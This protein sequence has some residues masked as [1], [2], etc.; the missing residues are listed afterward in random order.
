MSEQ[1]EQWKA[2]YQKLEKRPPR[3][4]FQK[5][6]AAIEQRGLTS[7]LAVD[8]GCGDGTE[9]MALLSAGWSVMAIDQSAYAIERVMTG[10][11]PGGSDRLQVQEASFDQ[12]ILPAADLIYAG[13]SLPFCAPEAFPRLWQKIRLA[14]RPGG[15]FAGHFFGVRDSWANK[16]HMTFHTAE[17]MQPLLAGLDIQYFHE[18]EDDRPSALEAMKHSHFFEVIA[19]QPPA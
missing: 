15:C 5:L 3:G 1:E 4:L 12:V 9:T 8:L 19:F 17:Q 18:G 11:A 14:L 6:M 16:P 13:L 7:G 2:Y 10:A